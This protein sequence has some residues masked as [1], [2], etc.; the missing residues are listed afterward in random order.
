MGEFSKK[1]TM[2]LEW[3]SMLTPKAQKVI[4]MRRDKSRFL[5]TITWVHDGMYES[6]ADKKYALNMTTHT[7]S[8]QVWQVSGLSCNHAITAI[9]HRHE[10]VT[11]YCDIYFTVQMYHTAYSLPFNPMPDVLEL[12]YIVYA[13]VMPPAA[14]RTVGW[15]KKIRKQTK[16][17]EIRH[18][19]CSRC[20]VV[21]HN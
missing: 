21:G 5:H 20:E 4:D 11:N 8:C 12:S 13:I 9:G 17:K 15:P 3:S 10:D 1:M 7:C 19:K 16:Y 14:R 6:N 2:F 18:L